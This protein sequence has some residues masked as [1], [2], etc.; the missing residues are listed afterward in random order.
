MKPQ[1]GTRGT[2]R[3]TVKPHFVFL[4]ASFEAD[5]GRRANSIFGLFVP[6]GG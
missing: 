1:K 4:V 2:K 5:I 6:F 3:K